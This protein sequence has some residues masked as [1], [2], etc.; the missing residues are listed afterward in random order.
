VEVFGLEAAKFFERAVKSALRRGAGA[1]DGDLKAVEFFA[2]HF[3][4]RS[5]FEIGAAAE[6]P[7]GMDDFAR[8]SLLE[9]RG[10]REFGETA[11]FELIEMVCSSGRTKFAAEKRPNLTAFWEMRAFPSAV[12]G[13]RDFS[14]FRRFARIR[15][16]LPFQ[17]RICPTDFQRCC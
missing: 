10:R 13:P 8:E 7:G 17:I 16:G 2:G 14:A 12:T 11:G 4:R 1:I 6:T 3:L 15:A 9:R 5:D